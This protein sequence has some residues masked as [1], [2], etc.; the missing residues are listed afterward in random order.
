MPLSRLIL[1]AMPA[2]LVL[3]TVASA[4]PSEGGATPFAGTIYQ[5]IAAAII[6]IL[7]LVILK[8]LAWGPILQGLVDRENKIK[9][10]LESAELA[11]KQ[12]TATLEQYRKQL[13]ESHAEARRIIEQGNADSEQQKARRIKETEDEIH[14]MKV[15][16]LAEIKTA[17]EQAVSELYAQ[18][19]TLATS[20]ASKI[21]HRELNA[22]DQQRLVE[23][24]IST[25][26]QSSNN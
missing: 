1:L 23:E 21:L 20:V 5:A 3:T 4:A 7:L 8:K 17:R 15:R 25:L 6:F 16:A 13:A 14:G 18:A 26:Q 10:D 22:A 9:S 11:A 24:S 2:T 19:A 12:A